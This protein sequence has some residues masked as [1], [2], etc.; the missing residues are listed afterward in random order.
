MPTI[1][2]ERRGGDGTESEVGVSGFAFPAEWFWL[3]WDEEDEGKEE[4]C[5]NASRNSGTIMLNAVL[6]MEGG[7]S[8]AVSSCTVGPKREA[9]C[10]VE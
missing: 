9:D 8:R 5:S 1:A 6:S 7:M 10:V 3:W 2:T 4:K